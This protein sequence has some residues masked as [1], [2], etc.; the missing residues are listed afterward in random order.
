[1]GVFRLA[2]KKE[3]TLRMLKEHIFHTRNTIKKNGMK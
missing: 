2:L 3:N 1:M